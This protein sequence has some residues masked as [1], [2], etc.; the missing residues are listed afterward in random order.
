MD[1]F[2]NPDESPG[3]GWSKANEYANWHNKETGDSLRPDLN[4]PVGKAPHVD[5]MNKK[6]S[7]HNYRIFKDGTWEAK[8][9]R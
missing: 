5:Y 1:L 6:N 2:N 3:E 8:K 4:H 9:K 7:E